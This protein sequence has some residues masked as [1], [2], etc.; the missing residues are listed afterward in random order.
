MVASVCKP[1]SSALAEV[2][3][4]FHHE[5]ALARIRLAMKWFAYWI[6]KIGDIFRGH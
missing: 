5:N 4:V 3:L 1:F 6:I 2:M